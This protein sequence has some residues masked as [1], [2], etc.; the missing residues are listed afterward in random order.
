M[1][2]NRNNS[3]DS[4]SCFQTCYGID[5]KAHFIKRENVIGKVFMDL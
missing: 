4:R 2:D 3:A 5:A 1:G